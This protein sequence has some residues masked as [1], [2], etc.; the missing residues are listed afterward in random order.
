VDLGIEE[1]TLPDGRPITLEVVRHAGGA[2]VAAVDGGG[3]VCLVRQY[4]HAAGGWIWEVPAG[5]LEPGES[6][7]DTAKRELEEEAGLL[8]ESWVGLGRILPTPGFCDEVIHLYLARDLMEV[9]RRPEGNE[10]IEVHRLDFGDALFR[11]RSGEIED[12]KTV[13]ALFRAAGLLEEKR[14]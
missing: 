11:A 3:R 5:K 14:R 12:A 2:A 13:A 9:P 7:L 10:L 6:P 8:A 1:A 4:R